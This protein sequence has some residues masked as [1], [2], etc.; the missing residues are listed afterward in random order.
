M[1]VARSGKG[2]RLLVGG[3]RI[4]RAVFV[5]AVQCLVRTF[6]EHFA[7]LNQAGCGKTGQGAKDHFL[8]ERGVHDP[9]RST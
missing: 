7:P 2:F 8:E 1:R 6:Y 4:A 3:E 9:L 5:A